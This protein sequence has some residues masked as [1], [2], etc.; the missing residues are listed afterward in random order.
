MKEIKGSSRVLKVCRL[1][2]ESKQEPRGP[3]SSES[4]ES[5]S[6][7]SSCAEPGVGLYC[8]TL[9]FRTFRTLSSCFESSGNAENRDRGWSVV[10]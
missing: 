3:E 5:K 8:L 6:I 4:S 7:D 9:N 10:F 1:R 2:F